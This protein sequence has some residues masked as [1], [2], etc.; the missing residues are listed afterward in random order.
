[1]KKILVILPRSI[2]GGLIME[3][4]ASGFELNKCRVMKKIVDELNIEDIED[5]RPDMIL[6]YDYSFLM[7]ENCTE[8]IKKSECKNLVFYFADEPRGKFA[9]GEKTYLYEE[10]KELNPKIFIWDRDFLNE[11]KNSSYLPLA[12]NPKKYITD[13]SAY[14]YSIS[15]VGRP[16]TDI[17]QEI[18]CELVKAFKNKLNIFSYEKHFLQ[19]VEEIKQKKLLS[20]E[21]LEIYS[22]CWR[23]FIE[24]EED[25]AEI[26]NSSKIN[27]NINLQGISSINYRVFEVLAAGGFLLTDEREDLKKYFEL[28]KHLETYKNTYELIDKINFYL[29]NLNIAQK[30]AQ[31]GKFETIENHTFSAR[32]RSILEKIAA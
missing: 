16:L 30:I 19:S 12:I 8:I 26:Y 2:A 4:F 20:E 24:K 9:L 10:L 27:L 18:L 14:K 28:S 17:R 25:L 1:M 32:A 31:L 21:D 5:F 7:D 22:N 11:F 23:G 6:G 15:F 3:G 29:Q 13:F